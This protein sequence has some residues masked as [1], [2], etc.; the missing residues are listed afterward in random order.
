MDYKHKY[1]KYKAKYLEAKAELEGGYKNIQKVLEKH[2][3]N[4]LVLEQAIKGRINKIKLQ[5]DGKN[6]GIESLKRNKAPVEEINEF[7]EREDFYINM[8][9]KEIITKNKELEKE[10]KLLEKAKKV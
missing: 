3:R 8:T 9:K 6:R 10:K 1:L 2:N 7:I 4:I 5:E